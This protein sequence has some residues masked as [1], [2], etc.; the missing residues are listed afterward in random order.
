MKRLGPKYNVFPFLGFL[1]YFV[2]FDIAVTAQTPVKQFKISGYSSD[3]YSAYNTRKKFPDEIKEQALIALSFYPEL[4]NRYITFRFRKRKTPLSSRPR[5]LSL[6]KR[7]KNRRYVITIST[8]T[9]SRLS[10]IL[11]TNLPYNAQIGVL[12]HEI[13]HVVEYNQ[14]TNVQIIGLAFRLLNP[15]YVNG[16]EFNTDRIVIKH[17]LGNQLYDW[18]SYVLKALDIK[19]WKGASNT[20]STATVQ[21]YMN[22]ETIEKEM[23]MYSIY[24]ES[25]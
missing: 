14:K 13:G 6:F 10:P 25:D 1:F 2:F 15:K 19:E 12:G 20:S 11:F 16:F 22:P 5:L 3:M 23:Q 17:G 24:K 4:K 21:R 8:K 9:T 18:S 7:K